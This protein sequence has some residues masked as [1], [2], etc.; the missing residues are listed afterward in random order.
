MH[1]ETTYHKIRELGEYFIYLDD[2]VL[3]SKKIEKGQFFNDDNKL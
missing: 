3:I 1:I 2:D